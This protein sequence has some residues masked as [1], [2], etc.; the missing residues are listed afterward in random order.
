MDSQFECVPS[1]YGAKKDARYRSSH[2]D[3]GGESS[4]IEYDHER[5]IHFTLCVSSE[6]ETGDGADDDHQDDSHKVA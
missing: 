2:D 6:A 5:W 1:E 4:D 3:E